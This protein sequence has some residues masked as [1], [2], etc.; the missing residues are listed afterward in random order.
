MRAPRPVPSPCASTDLEDP[1][2][3]SPASA[4]GGKYLPAPRAATVTAVP[5]SIDGM[6]VSLAVLNPTGLFFDVEVPHAPND[7]PMAGHW[8]WP[9]RI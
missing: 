1:C 8:N 5:D 7:E 2:P 6:T 3:S 4:A 9:P